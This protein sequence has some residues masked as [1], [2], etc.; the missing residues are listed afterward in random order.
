MSKTIGQR[1][2]E[3][4][5]QRGLTQVELARLVGCAPNTV[6]EWER[7]EGRAPGKKLLSQ[8]AQVLEISVDYLLGREKI[9]KPQIPCYG[10]V[11]SEEFLWPNT[12]TPKYYIEIPQSEFN[13]NRF[14]FKLLD[15]L[16]EPTV[17]KGD[18]GIFEKIS[19]QD[20]DIAIVH[21]P[22][23][24]K[25]TIKMWRQKNGFV[26]L[27]ETKLNKICPPYFFEIMQ[28]EKNLVYTLKDRGKIIV[29]GRLVA[30]KK[31]TKLSRASERINYI[32][33]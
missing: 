30:I 28:A 16:L 6:T 31:L 3:L 20:G 19:P 24:N 8:V 7:R 15:D 33:Q 29:E 23:D 1:I 4:R 11:L 32:F 12:N 13:P 10:E 22:G 9:D 21:F 2:K 18:Y 17:C 27:S 26:M 14:S 5:E 25:A